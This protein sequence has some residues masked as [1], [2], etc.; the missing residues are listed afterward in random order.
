MNRLRIPL[1]LA[2]TA[3]LTG[4]ACDKDRTIAAGET[5]T[6]MLSS[7]DP[8]LEADGSYYHTYTYR[9]R[10]NER[11][12]VT[13]RS[14]DF[15]THLAVGRG[16]KCEAPCVMDDDGAGGTDARLRMSLYEEGLY[17]IRVNTLSRGETGRYT[18]QVESE[19]APAAPKVARGSVQA[20]QTVSGTLDASDPVAYDDSYYE[21]WTFRPDFTG[22]V[23]ISLASGDF[24]AFLALGN[25]L[26]RDFA[27]IQSND[28]TAGGTD[29]QLTWKV[30]Q[31]R[32]YVIR[33]NALND[34]EQGAY[35]L[36]VQRVQ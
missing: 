25:G 1:L 28:D 29:A 10:D 15:D 22:T 5:I 20:G 8:Q 18:L 34:G 11:I 4:A 14:E 32:E 30:M 24:D 31:G 26:G 9:A 23:Q 16:E 13:L 6:G 3:A 27:D 36:A 7:G 35:T 21:D 17:T 19:D 12:T 2:A 33:A